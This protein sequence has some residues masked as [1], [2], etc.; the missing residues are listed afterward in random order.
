LSFLPRVA[1]HNVDEVIP[2]ISQSVTGLIDIKI[3]AG[4]LPKQQL[5][6]ASNQ[7]MDIMARLFDILQLE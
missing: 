5:P 1:S 3:I 6:D 7:I 4:V 2:S